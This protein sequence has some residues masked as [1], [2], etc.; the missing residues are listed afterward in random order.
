MRA[1]LLEKARVATADGSRYGP[2]GEGYLRIVFP[3]S[4][5]IFKEAIDR[6]EEALSTL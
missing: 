6:I 5:A 1:Y 3:T 4:K 2:G